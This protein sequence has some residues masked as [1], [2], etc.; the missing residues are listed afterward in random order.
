MEKRILLGALVALGVMLGFELLVAAS[1][2]ALDLPMDT[3]IG[4]V[5]LAGLLVNLLAMVAGGRIAREGFRV[6]AL[7]LSALISVCVV[8]SLQLSAAHAQLPGVFGLT[9]VLRYNALAFALGL[10]AAWSGA[11]LGERWA[12]HASSGGVAVTR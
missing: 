1:G 5:P 9:D 11:T 12:R 3:G 6:P 10:L 8:A 2:R 4:H 7:I